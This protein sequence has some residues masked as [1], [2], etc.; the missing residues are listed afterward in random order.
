MD[1]ISLALAISK[2]PKKPAAIMTVDWGGTLCDYRRINQ[3]SKLEEIPVIQDAAHCLKIGQEH[4]DYVT[5]SFGPIKHLTMSD[6]GALLCPELQWT[7]GMEEDCKLNLYHRAKLLRWFGIDRNSGDSFRCKNE[8]YLEGSKFHAND[9]QASIG[10][11]NMDLAV[12]CI[13]KARKNAEFYNR[14]LSNIPN[15][16]LPP[17]LPSNSWWLYSVVAPGNRDRLVNY[18]ES[19]NIMASPVHARNDKHPVFY[20]TLKPVNLD[21][22]EFFSNG[23][24]SIP[25]GWWVT[26]EEREY[27]VKKIKEFFS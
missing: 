15:L 25:V 1:P 20:H 5:W 17:C 22:L 3:I 24:L 8:I 4:G 26:R 13:E 11:S 18:L 27:I 7:R 2:C 23:Q 19:N 16:I 6:G 12:E 21:G 10:L 9:V 14:E